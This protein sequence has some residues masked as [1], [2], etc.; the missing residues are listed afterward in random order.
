MKARFLKPEEFD[1]L[2]TPGLPQITPYVPKR[3]AAVVVVEDEGRI[4]ACMTVAK[5]T[6]L[7]SV[8]IDPERRGSARIV[9]ELLTHAFALPEVRG[10][11]WVIG[12]A[13]HGDPQMRSYL[14]RLGGRSMDAQFYA[15]P[16]PLKL[17]GGGACRQQS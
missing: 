9:R 2:D 14:E 4:V 6:H 1:A 17:G 8:W 15:L 11:S 7:E 10:E 12:G 5:I 16:V 13:A 3:D